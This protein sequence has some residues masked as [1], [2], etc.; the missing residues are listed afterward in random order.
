[1]AVSTIEQSQLRLVLETGFDPVTQ[2]P[3]FKRKTFNNV[4]ANASA[5]G[6]Y[7]VAESLASLQQFGLE[8]V[9]RVDQV[10]IEQQ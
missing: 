2:N 3:T 6:L 7:S 10:K 4:K 8:K 5:E 1:M 9:E